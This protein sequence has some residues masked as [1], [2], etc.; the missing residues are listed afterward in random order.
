[1]PD[2]MIDRRIRLAIGGQTPR[3]H[4]HYAITGRTRSHQSAVFE[5]SFK[6]RGLLGQCNFAASGD[7]PLSRNGL[8]E[9]R[10]I[11]RR[12]LPRNGA[13]QNGMIIRP[14][15]NPHHVPRPALRRKR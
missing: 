6:I 15:Q 2:Q 5:H 7:A 1:M 12:E 4:R 8:R 13:F 3:R 10:R 11:E 14:A 9:Q